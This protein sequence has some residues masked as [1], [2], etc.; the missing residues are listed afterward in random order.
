MIAFG[1]IHPPAGIDAFLVPAH[2]LTASWLISSVL[3]GS[4]M[5][6]V[7]GKLWQLGE[8]FFTAHDKR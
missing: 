3:P 8:R 6:A 4:L 7:F 5:L 2:E 1:A